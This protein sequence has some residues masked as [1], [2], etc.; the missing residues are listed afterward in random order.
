L[1]EALDA[2]LR[3]RRGDLAG[4]LMAL[5]ASDVGLPAAIRRRVPS[6]AQFSERQL[7]ADVL[8]ALGR[9]EEASRW[10]TSLHHEPGVWGLPFLAPGFD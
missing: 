10:V 8:T 3:F 1:R 6:L 4:A 5:Q 9:Q 7:H 2:Q